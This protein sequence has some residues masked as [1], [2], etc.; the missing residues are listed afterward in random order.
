MVLGGCFVFCC[1]LVIGWSMHVA[2]AFLKLSGRKVLSHWFPS[3]VMLVEVMS[4]FWQDTLGQSAK[5]K[6]MRPSEPS[7]PPPWHVTNPKAEDTQLN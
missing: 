7:H 5:A 1:L 6:A 3:Q 2:T 4:G